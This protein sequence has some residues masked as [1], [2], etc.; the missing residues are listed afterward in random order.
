MGAEMNQVKERPIL[1]SGE[2]VR[3]ILD[4]R[5]TQTRRVCKPQPYMVLTAEQWQNRALSGVDG[6]MRPMG[7]WIE[8]ELL[9]KCQY[10]QP[11]D[12]LYVR[13]T[14]RTGKRLDHLSPSGIEL[15]A[16]DAGWEQGPFGPLW[17]PSDDSYRQ[18]GDDDENNFGG[19][20][21]IRSSI[22]MPRWAS[23]ILLEIT[24]VRVE[25]LQDISEEDARAEGYESREDFLAGEWA[26]VI[27]ERYG[28]AWVWVIKFQKITP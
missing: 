3:A 17:Y 14:W 25:R 28:N 16:R 27:I 12:R 1:F 5:K 20:G 23:R 11:G 9:N 2:M 15:Q 24:D 22:H 13:E 10:G 8:E 6:Y 18:W 19:P 21:R 7:S 4:G 26:R